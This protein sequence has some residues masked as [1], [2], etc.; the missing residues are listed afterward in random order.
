MPLYSAADSGNLALSI[1]TTVSRARQR[2]PGR[3]GD[4]RGDG[5]A[6]ERLVGLLGRMHVGQGEPLAA[7][8]TAHT[9]T[10]RPGDKVRREAY[11]G[12]IV[13][14]VCNATY[15]SLCRSARPTLV[16]SCILSPTC[17]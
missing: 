9:D 4:A 14:V 7:L 15:K 10:F 1:N 13:F 16:R 3:T 17:I 2:S 8:P 6:A 12:W 11:V 5:Q